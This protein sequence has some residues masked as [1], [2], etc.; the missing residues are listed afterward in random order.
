MREFFKG[1]ALKQI[2]ET[3]AHR[4]KPLIK[5]GVSIDEMKEKIAEYEKKK[6]I[7]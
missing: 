3:K 7:F 2:I 5:F 6:T 1:D 4:L